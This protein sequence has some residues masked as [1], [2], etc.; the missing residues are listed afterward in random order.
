MLE[1]PRAGNPRRPLRK[2]RNELLPRSRRPVRAPVRPARGRVRHRA[3]DLAAPAARGQRADARDRNGDPG[4]RLRLSAPPVPDDRH[5][6]DRPVP[7]DRLLPPARLGHRDRLPDRRDPLGRG[8]VHRD[9]RRGALEREDGRGRQA[10]PQAGAQRRV[11]G[12]IGHGPARRRARA[13]RRRGL[14]LGADRLAGQ[15]AGLGD[16]RPHRP[17]LRRLADLGL[18]ASRR[19]HLHEGGGRR[20]RPRREDRGGHPRGRSPQPGRDRGQRGRQR[21]RLRGHGRRPLRDLCRHGGRGHAARERVPGQR[22]VALPAGHRRDLDHRLDHRH[23]L[24]ADRARRLDHERALQVRDRGHAALGDR[25]HPGDGGVRRRHVQLL[26]P[27]R[28]GADRPRHHVP[29]RRDH[30]VLHGHALGPGEVDFERVTHGARDEHHRGA[31]RGHAGDGAAGDRDRDRDRR[32]VLRRGAGAVRDRR[33]GH[34]AALDDRPDRRS[35]RVRPG[36]RQRGRHRRDGEPRRVGAGDH[37]SAGRG[38]EHDE[39]G[40]E[41]LRDRV[42]RPRR[43]DPVRRVHARA[44]GSRARD[45]HV[46]ARRIHGWSRACSSAA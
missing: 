9:E 17:R 19:R 36:D 15:L 24:R 39:G 33:R 18:R 43:A 21:R 2:A 27:L 29:A 31:R 5:R 7:P 46:L 4:G 14:L 25:V 28:L 20:R 35:R 22:A 6:R 23:V 30:R 13:A 10:R 1:T 41:G 44:P 37:G 45:D 12:R 8:R 40:H 42:G 34:G 38:R 32:R 3:H 11:P 16:R 26:E